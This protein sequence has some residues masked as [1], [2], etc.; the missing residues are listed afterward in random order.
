MLCAPPTAEAALGSIVCRCRVRARKEKHTVSNHLDRPERRI[1]WTQQV[2]KTVRVYAQKRTRKNVGSTT[3]MHGASAMRSVASLVAEDALPIQPNPAWDTV[4][5]PSGSGQGAMLRKL[6]SVEKV[7]SDSFHYRAVNAITRWLATPIWSVGENRL[8]RSPASLYKPRCI[9]YLPMR[10]ERKECG[11]KKG[12]SPLYAWSIPHDGRGRD[13][14]PQASTGGSEHAP[15]RSHALHLVAWS[16]SR[17]VVPGGG[18]RIEDSATAVTRVGPTRPLRRYTRATLRQ[19][20]VGWN[21][22][23]PPRRILHHHR[24][25]GTSFFDN[26]EIGVNLS[27]GNR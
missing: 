4:G 15:S 24:G 9:L 19:Q 10:S 6:Q 16:P 2:P 8:L 26:D 13:H 5:H 7:K 17:K 11:E 3:R 20:E 18:G 25:P 27:N 21:P 12:R 1:R 22:V 14:Y 23:P